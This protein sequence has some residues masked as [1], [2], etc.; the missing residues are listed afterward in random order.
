MLPDMCRSVILDHGSITSCLVFSVP[1]PTLPEDLVSIKASGMEI[2]QF[3]FQ[4]QRLGGI[5]WEGLREDLM[6]S[7]PVTTRHDG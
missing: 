4:D 1:N 5:D 3:R 2:R 6:V 7:R